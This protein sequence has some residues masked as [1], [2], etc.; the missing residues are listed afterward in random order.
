MGRCS[1]ATR[2]AAGRLVGSRGRDPNVGDDSRYDLVRYF[3]VTSQR[4][5]GKTPAVTVTN[6]P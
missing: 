3:N 4:A 2:I 5:S 6:R 1:G